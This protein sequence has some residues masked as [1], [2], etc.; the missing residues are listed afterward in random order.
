MENIGTTE[1]VD[2]NIVNEQQNQALENYE[3]LQQASL[4]T[5]ENVDNNEVVTENNTNEEVLLAGKYKTIED[6]DNGIK[7]IGSDLPDYILNGMNQETK[8][9]YYLE[10]Q[11][12]FSSG[13]KNNI[14]NN[15][16]VEENSGLNFDK[17]T[18][19]LLENDGK[20]TEDSYKE[21]EKIGLPKN[22]VDQYIQGQ[23]LIQIQAQENYDNEITSDIGGIEN[24]Q[25]MTE[26]A[27]EN[28]SEFEQTQ[29]NKILDSGDLNN[30]KFAI[31]NLYNRMEL[32]NKEVD[33]SPKIIQ[34]NTQNVSNQNIGFAN[35]TEFAKAM[36]DKRYNVDQVY[37]NEVRQK[38]ANTPNEIVFG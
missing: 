13:E 25:K 18:K 26:W 7:N 27:N 9:Q 32:S 38:M 8:E 22:I 37:T 16:V 12:K 1:V 35:K 30:T 4:A 31:N 29:F 33:N 28:L 20:L 21:L 15:E 14:E 19:E 24:Y 3:K 5:E 11:K 10:L 6:L 17:Y 2:Q 36:T 23:N 34:G